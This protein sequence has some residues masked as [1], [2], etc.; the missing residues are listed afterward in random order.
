MQLALQLLDGLFRT[1]ATG[2]QYLQGDIL[3]SVRKRRAIAVKRFEYGPPAAR[4]KSFL[5]DIPI[6]Q[7]AADR[8][9]DRGIGLRAMFCWVRHHSALAADQRDSFDTAL[10]SIECM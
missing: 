2:V 4:S 9:G 8:N 3:L 6:P 10:V 1:I 7:N 5:D